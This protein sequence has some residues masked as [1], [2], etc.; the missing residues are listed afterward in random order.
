MT[1]AVTLAGCTCNPLCRPDAALLAAQPPPDCEF[2]G[3]D[4]KV[5]DVDEMARL[6][7]GYE[8]QCYRKAEKAARDRLSLLQASSVCVIGARHQ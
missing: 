2:K 3:A 8:R 1:C 4:N 7:I 5:M 6:K